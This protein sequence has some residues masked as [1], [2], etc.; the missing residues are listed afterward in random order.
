VSVEKLK[1]AK[2]E[3]DRLLDHLKPEEVH[4]ETEIKG[5]GEKR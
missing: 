2:E 5:K 3:R 1:I 4:K